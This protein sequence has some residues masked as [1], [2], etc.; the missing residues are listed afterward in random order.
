MPA[1]NSILN[2]DKA[3]NKMDAIVNLLRIVYEPF[4]DYDLI[5]K[6]MGEILYEPE[7]IYL[8][9]EMLLGILMLE[10]E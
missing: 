10:Y 4:E 1:S 3:L 6:D 9:V 5:L 7:H 8:I 2:D